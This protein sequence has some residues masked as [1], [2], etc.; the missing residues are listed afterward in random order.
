MVKKPDSR[1][2]RK[3]EVE[4]PSKDEFRGRRDPRSN[5][6]RDSDRKDKKAE[7]WN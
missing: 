7:S 1:D 5:K 2:V 6:K 3:N 4:E